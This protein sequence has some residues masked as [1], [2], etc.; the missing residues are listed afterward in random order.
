MWPHWSGYGL[1]GEGVAL[2]EKV[3]PCWSR[4]GLAGESVSPQRWAL[5]S[6][7]LKARLSVAVLSLL[8]EAQNV[9]F[10]APSPS[11]CLPECYHV[12]YHDNN[13]LNL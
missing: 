2:L 12:S 6:H 9:E 13:E 7:M 11:P 4:C 10:S 3:W 1:V 8:P 5:R